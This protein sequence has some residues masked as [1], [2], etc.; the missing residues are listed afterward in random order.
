MS[1]WGTGTGTGTG[2]GSGEVTG[3]THGDSSRVWCCYWSSSI[4]VG[5]RSVNLELDI[6]S[7]GT[8]FREHTSV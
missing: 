1:E 2:S 3:C 5:R 4:P 8:H 6:N 7:S